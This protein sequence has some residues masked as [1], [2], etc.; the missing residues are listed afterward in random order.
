MDRQSISG[1]ARS[2][3]DSRIESSTAEAMGNPGSPSASP[4]SGGGQPAP[5]AKVSADAS[6]YVVRRVA[7]SDG[8]Y[9][10]TLHVALGVRQPAPDAAA[11]EVA[12]VLACAEREGSTV[13]L[14][15]AAQSGSRLVGAAAALE[16]PGASAFVFASSADVSDTAVRGAGAAVGALA[17]EAQ[18]RTVRIL[19][20]LIDPTQHWR[21]EILGRG[22]FRHLTRLLYLTRRVAKPRP[23]FVTRVELS[24]NT[25]HEDRAQLFHEALDATYVESLDC[26]ELTGLRPTADVLAG[27]RGSVNFD[28]AIWFVAM[29]G[30]APAG[31]VLLN[32]IPGGD[33]LELAYMGVAQV[34]RG[35]GVANALLDRAVAA[36]REI[37]AKRLSLAVDHRN[38]PAR[39]MYAKWGFVETMTREA[40][41][42]PTPGAA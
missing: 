32:R 13:D 39:Q 9:L 26:P 15:F 16:S 40:W 7:P 19:E 17:K 20:A 33:T 22:G 25:Y 8:D 4:L 42:L 27:H 28:P 38:V 11:P 35:K 23:K 41:I 34:W 18:G 14:V 10:E 30:A 3:A 24:W 6:E 5:L 31:V 29:R 37:G 12:D 2:T 36:A 1:G 21:R